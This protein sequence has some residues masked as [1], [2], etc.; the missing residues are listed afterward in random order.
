MEAGGG[1]GTQRSLI[2]RQVFFFHPVR[3]WEQVVVAG[4][5]EPQE[6]AAVA[7]VRCN[8]GE[9]FSVAVGADSLFVPNTAGALSSFPDDLLELPE[10]HDALLLHVL[11]GRHA[12]DLTY[13][14]IGEMVLSV[15]PHKRIAA[16]MDRCMGAYLSHLDAAQLPPGLA[17][18]VWG[19]A[20]RAY[21]EMRARQV[22]YSIIASG[23]SGSGKTEA[24]KKMLKYLCAA[25]ERVGTD[26]AVGKRM[27]RISERVQLSS[28]VLESFGNA[29]TVKNDNSSRFGKFMEVQFDAKGVMVGLR[30]TPFLLERSRA[31]TCGA[32]ERV[33]HVF[34]QLVAGADAASRQR[35][36]LGSARDF[37][38]LGKGG[39]LPL[40]TGDTDDARAFQVL[41]A[42]L[43]SLG[44]SEEEQQTL[45]SVVG[46]VLHLQN[47]TFEMRRADDSAVLGDG[48]AQTAAFVAGQLLR[49]PDPAVFVA[50]LTTSTVVVGGDRVT[51]KL[52]LQKAGD[53]RDSICKFLYSKLFLFVVQKVN[54]ATASGADF[55]H[56]EV[57]RSPAE[58]LLSCGLS[59]PP[60]TWIALLDIFG[61]EDFPVNSLEQFC[62]NL[63]NE[64]LQRQYTEKMFLADMEEMRTEGVEPNITEF[65]DN[66]L[67]LV[68]LQGSKNSI[69]SHLDDASRLDVQ[70]SHTNPDFA[71]LNAITSAF[72]PDYQSAP[73]KALRSVLDRDEALRTP[74][75][76][77]YRGRLDDSSF[78]VR[79][80]AGD[81][82]YCVN[83]FVEKN[84][85]YV[86]DACAQTLQNTT[87]WALRD[88]M[89][90]T[91]A[92]VGLLGDANGP[93]S[94]APA[95][96]RAARHTVAS[97][98]RNS[99]RLLMEM[100]NS[101]E[102]NWV[103]C[104]RPHARRQ[105]GLF[106]G[107]LVLEQLV[108]TGVL[109]TVWQRQCNY[110]FRLSCGEFVRH[111]HLFDPS[112]PSLRANMPLRGKCLALLQ[113]AGISEKAAQVG[114]ARVFLTAD[115]HRMLEARR[116]QRAQ[117]AVMVVE[118]YL[119]AFAARAYVRLVCVTRHT[120][121]LQRIFRGNVR[122]R[123][124]VRQYYAELRRKRQERF[125]E[126][127]KAALR[128]EASARAAL[129]N[130]REC[131]VR[132]EWLEFRTRLIPLV[133]AV[134]RNLNVVEAR[135]RED[136]CAQ[137]FLRYDALRDAFLRGSVTALERQ[138]QRVAMKR[139]MDAKERS[140]L[141]GGALEA[142][143]AV[144]V[145]E[146]AA[147]RELHDNVLAPA[148]RRL[149]AQARRIRRLRR[150]RDKRLREL[151]DALASEGRRWAVVEAEALHREA[152][153]WRRIVGEEAYV[154]EMRYFAA[155]AG[156]GSA[157]SPVFRAFLR[158]GVP[159]AVLHTPLR[160][161]PRAAASIGGVASFRGYRDYMRG[162]FHRVRG[163][164]TAPDYRPHAHRAE[165]PCE[166]C[167]FALHPPPREAAA[168]SPTP[169][170]T[171]RRLEDEYGDSDDSFDELRYEGRRGG[172]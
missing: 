116:A 101:S 95:T 10:L 168:L 99:L 108:A 111:Y 21:V 23:E 134:L 73:G 11:R 152:A 19:V 37:V 28:V 163:S 123:R 118:Q 139:A 140:D 130:E 14:R 26:A 18:H 80:Y 45:W 9:T 64:S 113:T 25:S 117:A 75:D 83:G 110:P 86:K 30:V 66:Q 47:I 151:H 69:I 159:S 56:A 27:Q 58:H 74:A 158:E 103:R 63:A 107:K 85:D 112:S 35:L 49:L 52:S 142:L 126:L 135:R 94:P 1:D 92:M 104:I 77:F 145:E 129:R 54:A 22:N 160:V 125:L 48:D 169:R 34:Y 44:F 38:L 6:R 90:T 161:S 121:K 40:K 150:W 55:D 3:A 62:I 78:T 68:L 131:D 51:K 102:C 146:E 31:V 16:Q 2:G 41:Q 147:F 67:C 97:T 100:L 8:S 5:G 162:E 61:F 137:A 170:P 156:G 24:C 172:T 46:A 42:A 115:A 164:G 96:A 149:R 12:R 155:L 79:H 132:K 166:L 109:S 36:R 120:V 98:F 122:I 43:T 87:S 91:D 144:A 93:G 171:P 20:H 33:Y 39:C 59:P 17:P 119:A 53:Q 141:L 13:M 133:A 81:V 60:T 57:S 143:R 88:V 157:A 32:D 15:N 136:T 89:G 105:A 148:V 124:C 84:N 29:K 7:V 114:S 106:D 4:M 50:C 70:R 72:C 165:E 154:Q 153:R 65:V 82:K 127:T 76:Y 71:F 167:S 138:R 128:A